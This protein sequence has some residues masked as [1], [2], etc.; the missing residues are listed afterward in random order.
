M[1]FLGHSISGLFTHEASC[2]GTPGDDNLQTGVS[3]LQQANSLSS[4]TGSTQHFALA[5]QISQNNGNNQLST[6]LQIN[7][8]SNP[9]ASTCNSAN[10]NG[11]QQ[12]V[13]NLLR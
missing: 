5:S 12:Q 1:V 4:D 13:L 6:G 8:G 11:N 2:L 7:G 10:N 9:S 3:T